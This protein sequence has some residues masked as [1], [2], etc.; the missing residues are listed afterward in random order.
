LSWLKANAEVTSYHLEITLGDSVVY[1]DTSLIT[2][3]KAITGLVKDNTYTWHV[4][5]KNQSGWG[6]WST[7]RN[8]T[9]YKQDPTSVNEESAWGSLVV[10]PQPA[11]EEA[12]ISGIDPAATAIYIYDLAGSKVF[13]QRLSPFTTSATLDIST[14]TKGAYLVVAGRTRAY[15]IVR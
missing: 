9:T 13:E 12:A 6:S 2:L 7:E 15:V 5:A 11:S 10:S 1:G 8:F 14:L 3:T 4:R